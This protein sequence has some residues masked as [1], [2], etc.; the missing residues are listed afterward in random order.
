LT[1]ERGG[2]QFVVAAKVRHFLPEAA[3]DSG[4]KK[5]KK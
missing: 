5:K 4:A 1:I 3:D 2:K